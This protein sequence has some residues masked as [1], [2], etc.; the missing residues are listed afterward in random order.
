VGKEGF[1]ARKEAK[2][3][4]QVLVFDSRLYLSGSV[5]EVKVGRIRVAEDRLQIRA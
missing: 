3:P 5:L 1:A 4:T 2:G